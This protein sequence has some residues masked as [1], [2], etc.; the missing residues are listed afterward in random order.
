[1]PE[2]EAAGLLDTSVIIDLNS[3]NASVLPAKIAIS[4][5]SLAEIAAGPAATDDVAERARR[6]DRLQRV[7]A[8]F[9]PIPFD[10]EAARA[11]GRIYAA[12]VA[13]G[14]KPRRRLADLQIAAT[15]L[16]NDMTLITRNPDDFVGLDDLIRVVAV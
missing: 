10:G 5:V 12:V 1:M 8:T 11:Y 16:A 14:R 4:T 15:A 6:Q 2:D 3:I 13:V 9:E 7:E